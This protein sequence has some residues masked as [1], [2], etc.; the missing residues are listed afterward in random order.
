MQR[1]AARFIDLPSDILLH[2]FGEC[3]V[4]DIL[5]LSSVRGS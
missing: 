3:D 1:D 5:S 4:F 2:V